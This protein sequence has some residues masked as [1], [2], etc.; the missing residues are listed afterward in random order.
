[1]NTQC[2]KY[3]VEM[4]MSGFR[5]TQKRPIKVLHL[6][7]T[8]IVGGPGR[9]ILSS[10]TRIDRSRFQVSI[11]SCLKRREN[12]LLQ[13]ARSR[14]IPCYWIPMHSTFDPLPL[15]QLATLLL[16]L[17][18]DI[19]HTHGY[20]SNLMAFLTAHAAG[21]RIVAT[22]HGWT[23]ESNRVRLYERVDRLLLKKMDRVVAVSEKKRMELVQLGI[24]PE[25]IRSVP[26]AILLPDPLSIP[27]LR[28]Q[29]RQRLGVSDGE[30]VVGSVGRLSPEKGHR[31]LLLVLPEIFDRVNKTQVVIV[32]DGHERQELERLSSKLGIGS[33]L[34]FTGYLP[35]AMEILAGFDIFVLPSHSEGLPIALLEACGL[36]MACLATDVGGVSEVIVHGKSGWLVPP[37]SPE[38]LSQGLIRLLTD[39]EGRHQM[40]RE[41][42]RQVRERYNIDARVKSEEELYSEL[43]NRTRNH[44]ASLASLKKAARPSLSFGKGRS[45]GI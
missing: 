40:G 45:G 5:S 9:L 25:K 21:A 13:E 41:A 10:A 2:Q 8:P 38:Q 23:G 17:K 27:K 44:T 6:I 29:A 34:V 4:D 32:G 26:N 7:T 19:V 22:A 33:R 39:S 31:D 37:K 1:M 3:K 30:I 42:A 36:G 16:R 14:S 24:S 15:A 28:A 35:N 20:R 12:E 43:M 18:I 11:A